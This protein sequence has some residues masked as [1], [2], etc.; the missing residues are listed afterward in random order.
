MNRTISLKIKNYQMTLHDYS[1]D[2]YKN[3]V[4]NKF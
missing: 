2:T 1:P 4:F 3:D